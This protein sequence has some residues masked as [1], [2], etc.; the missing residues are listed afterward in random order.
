MSALFLTQGKT[1]EIFLDVADSLSDQGEIRDPIFFVSDSEHFEKVKSLRGKKIA[2]QYRFIKE[3]EIFRR[4]LELKPDLDYLLA[5]EHRFAD[6]VLWNAAIA[7]RRLSL[8]KKASFVQD[9]SSRYSH[10]QTLS[11]L[12]QTARSLI[13]A[14][15][16]AKPELVVGFICVTVADYLAFLISRERGIPF[17]N[18]RPTRVKNFFV[19]GTTVTEPSENIRA[20]Y[21]KNYRALTSGAEVDEVAHKD[22]LDFV[23]GLQEGPAMYEGVIPASTLKTRKK[24]KYSIIQRV[25]GLTGSIVT[26]IARD[27]RNLIA[28]QYADNY[29]RPGVYWL[30]M[31]KY[32]KPKRLRQ[33]NSLSSDWL[34]IC[35]MPFAFFPLHKEPEVTMLVYGR[36]CLNQ[37]EVIRNLAYSLPAGMKLV[38]KEHP[39]AVGYRAKSYYEAILSIPNV[40]MLNPA[41]SSEVVIPSAQIV[42]VVSGSIGFEAVVKRKPVL[43]LGDAPFNVLSSSMVRHVSDPSKW[44]DQ[45]KDMLSY[46]SY[47]ENSLTAYIMAIMAEGIPVN[48][49]SGLLEREG[50]YS[51][52]VVLDHRKARKEEIGRLSRYIMAHA[53]RL[54]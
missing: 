51:G 54:D 36:H 53:S 15:D 30:F 14:F 38:V 10:D 39:V 1:L 29:Y 20:A 28:N 25:K 17:V 9:Y 44:A 31:Q 35:G 3:W 26:S 45:V 40:L 46:S 33:I 23:R 13:D 16:Q 19:A 43:T 2:D 7:D 12:E 6:P 8:G 4:G 18:L 5:F 41:V 49:Y 21:Q 50:A 32:L 42:V 48:F 22:A 34:E 47:D 27:T 24:S 11:I 52:S 37:I